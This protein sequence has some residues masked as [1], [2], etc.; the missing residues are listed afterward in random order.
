MG[1]MSTPSEHNSMQWT[2]LAN[3]DSQL[4]MMRKW[5]VSQ[6]DPG[7]QRL[8]SARGTAMAK[9]GLKLP[10]TT[11]LI[12]LI[13]GLSPGSIKLWADAEIG[14]MAEAITRP[15]AVPVYTRITDDDAEAI[16]K[17][18]LTRELH[19]RLMAPDPYLGE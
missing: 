2:E 3:L 15:G 6:L 7:F 10:R 11:T 12:K 9:L 19:D 4:G 13:A 8:L 18:D 17:G 16:I 14:W 5:G 1:T